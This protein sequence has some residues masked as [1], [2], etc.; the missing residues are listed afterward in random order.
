MSTFNGKIKF[1]SGPMFGGKSNALM[2]DYIRH[3]LAHKK[4]LLIKYSKDN[5]YEGHITHDSNYSVSKDKKIY[6]DIILNDFT[7]S[8]LMEADEIIIDYDIIFIDEI[9]FFKDNYIFCEKWANLG[10]EIVLAGLMSTFER[11]LF[12]GMEK[13]I[14]LIENININPAVCIDNGNDAYFTQRTTCDKEETI[15]GNDNI[16]KAVDRRT[17][18]DN[19]EIKLNNY[20]NMVIDFNDVYNE[21]NK[22]ENKIDIDKVKEFIIIHNYDFNLIECVMNCLI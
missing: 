1:Y 6:R 16:Y 22:T 20:L 15:I 12:V 9:Q 8:Y 19:E 2:N 11:K 21:K 10:K 13:L 7:C 14:P 17:Y 18:Y 5:R 4:C 3:S